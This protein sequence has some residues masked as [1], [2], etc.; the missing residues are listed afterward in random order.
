MYKPML[1][2]DFDPSRVEYPVYVEPK[3]DGVR[4]V[5]HIDFSTNRIEMFFRSGNPVLS[6]LHIEKLLMNSRKHFEDAGYGDKI[7][8]DGEVTHP[9]GYKTASGQS[10]WIHEQAPE[11]EYSIFDAID[12]GE[13]HMPYVDRITKLNKIEYAF[14]DNMWVVKVVPSLIAED[15]GEVNEIYADYMAKGMEGVMVKDANAPY[16]EKRSF[17]WMKMKEELSV[18]I[19][20]V[21]F[22]EGQGKYKEMLGGVI[23]EIPAT[24]RQVRVGSGFTDSQRAE[25]WENQND[26]LGMTAEIKYQYETHLGSLRHPV[27]KTWRTDK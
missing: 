7:F 4:V 25:V 20:I 14:T 8:L 17:Y 12:D 11:L 2:K 21:G 10:R 24:G 22:F 3:L 15:L 18:D 6:L 27:F 9:D 13:A 1:A 23:A 19:P 26:Y 5:A 16:V